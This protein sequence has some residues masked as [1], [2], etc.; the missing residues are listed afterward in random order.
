MQEDLTQTVTS[1]IRAEMARQGVTQREIAEVLG[2][3][4]SQV[5][6]R[7]LGQIAFNVPEL[8]RIAARLHVPVTQLL[9]SPART[10]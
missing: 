5:S 9:Q 6:L 8:E 7:L 2:I 4:Q 3:S 1:E 10:P